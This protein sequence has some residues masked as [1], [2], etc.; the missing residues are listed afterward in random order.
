M[1]KSLIGDKVVPV[2]AHDPLKSP[3]IKNIQTA[4]FVGPDAKCF[5]AIEQNGEMKP[6]H[7]DTC[8]SEQILTP[9]INHGRTL[10]QASIY[11]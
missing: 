5:T 11:I 2:V 1:E 6:K 3:S 4:M 8:S 7:P 10:S 9:P